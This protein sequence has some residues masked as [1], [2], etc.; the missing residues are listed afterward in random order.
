MRAYFTSAAKALLFITAIVLASFPLS[1]AANAATYPITWTLSPNIAFSDGGTLNG[2]FNIN[3]YDVT[4]P[5]WDLVTAGGSTNFGVDY[6]ATINADDPN[7]LT[8]KFNAPPQGAD[9]GYSSFL[10]IVFQNS[11][12]VPI[13]NNPIVGGNLGP[14]YECE[15]FGDTSGNCP[16]PIRYI[17]GGYASA[18]GLTAATPLPAALPLFAGGAGVIGLFARGK[19]RKKTVAV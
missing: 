16:G 10:Y 14:S 7:V 12:L 13:A 3:Q 9:H 5:P 19:R 18:N 1:R 17:L 11:L 2:F 4:V 15:N 8:V 6:N